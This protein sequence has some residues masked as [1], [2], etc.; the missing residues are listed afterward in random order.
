[1]YLHIGGNYMVDIHNIVAFFKTNPK[2]IEKT[3]SLQKYYRPF[4]FVEDGKDI[5]IRSYIL[6]DNYIYG[7]PLTL[8]T[9]IHRYNQLFKLLKR[10]I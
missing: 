3:N 5:K 6:T 10:P 8:K 4:I 1:M 7:S 2:R 9:I